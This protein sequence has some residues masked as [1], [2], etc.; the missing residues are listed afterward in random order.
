[1]WGLRAKAGRASGH[2]L[3]GMAGADFRARL[4]V[5]LT[6]ALVE[7]NGRDREP[8]LSTAVAVAPPIAHRRPL[9]RHAVRFRKPIAVGIAPSA[10]VSAKV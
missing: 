7:L 6:K 2:V 8:A 5:S 1:M 10:P 9:L 3:E 4:G